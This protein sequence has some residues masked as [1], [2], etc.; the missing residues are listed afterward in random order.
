MSHQ[1]LGR[2]RHRHFFDDDVDARV[3]RVTRPQSSRDQLHRI[4]HLF[5]EFLESTASAKP[6]PH[7]RNESD[8]D[9]KDRIEWQWSLCGPAEHHA[10]DNA[11]GTQQEELIRTHRRVRLLEEHPHVLDALERLAD[12]GSD[13][14]GRGL[15]EVFLHDARFFG[16]GR[17]L[18][19]EDLQPIFGRRAADVVQQVKH[20]CNDHGHANEDGCRNQ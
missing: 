5:A 7:E 4:R 17:L 16:L 12:D 13:A 1:K 9:S 3:Q 14:A 8:P 18:A 11:A 2:D 6:E 19:G 20:R 10:D 15:H